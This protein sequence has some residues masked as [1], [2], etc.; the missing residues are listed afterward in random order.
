MKIYFKFD[1][2][3]FFLKKQEETEMWMFEEMTCW[4]ELGLVPNIWDSF[5][6]FLLAVANQLLVTWLLHSLFMKLQLNR[7]W[8]PPRQSWKSRCLS[9]QRGGLG[10]I[11]GMVFCLMQIDASLSL[12]CVGVHT[13][14][15]SLFAI[16]IVFWTVSHPRHFPTFTKPQMGRYLVF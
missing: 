8:A 14:L 13:I 4:C 11:P 3:N 9:V 16:V 15:N 5:L 10:W 6:V 1:Q 7:L 12:F 2:I